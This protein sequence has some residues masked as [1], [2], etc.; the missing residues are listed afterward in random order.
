MK[1]EFDISLQRTG[2]PSPFS[3]Q[4]GQGG[5]PGGASQ[6]RW[7]PQ[8][9]ASFVKSSFT[10]RQ[11]PWD[12]VLSWRMCRTQTPAQRRTLAVMRAG[13]EMPRGWRS[14]EVPSQEGAC[15]GMVPRKA[16]GKPLKPGKEDEG[17]E[18][19][20]KLSHAPGA[21]ERLWSCGRG[22]IVG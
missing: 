14:P 18:G 2:G 12:L 6:T 9:S 4:C 5:H 3:L 19:C 1:E 16:E 17:C 10:G 15:R 22:Q 7:G 21:L 13:T 20:S 8:S 11:S